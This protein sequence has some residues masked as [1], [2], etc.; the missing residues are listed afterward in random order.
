MM[1]RA[2]IL[3]F[4]SSRRDDSG[5][6]R[7]VGSTEA[8]PACPS[9]ARWMQNVPGMRALIGLTCGV[10][11]ACGTTDDRPATVEVVSLEILA[12][13]CGS[14]QCH[15]TTTRLEGL[16]FDTL[17][18]AKASMRRLEVRAGDGGELLE[19]IEENEMPPDS[20]MLDNDIRLIE[21]WIEMGAAGL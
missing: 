18:E 2:Q 20:P 6:F 1:S 9:R 21:A 5:E 3:R 14:V 7:I 17:D 15:S 10:M 13:T 4:R 8:T 19:V 11:I 12:P 16:A